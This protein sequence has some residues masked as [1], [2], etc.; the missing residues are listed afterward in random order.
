M[1]HISIY[2]GLWWI[3]FNCTELVVREYLRIQVFVI[4]VNI[5]IFVSESNET[6]IH[7]FQRKKT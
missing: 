7:W 6:K 5:K 4:D 3:M 2:F 1:K